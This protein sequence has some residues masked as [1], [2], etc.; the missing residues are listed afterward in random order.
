MKGLGRGRGVTP[1]VK[2]HRLG[3]GGVK[4]GTHRG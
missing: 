3:W 2:T 1:G 4:T